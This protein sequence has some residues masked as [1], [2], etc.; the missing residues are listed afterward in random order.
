MSNTIETEIRLNGQQ[1][2]ETLKSL[3]SEV[4][5]LTSAW[6][7]EEI[8]LKS[9]GDHLQA[10]K[11][12]Y[13]GLS[14]TVNKQKEYIQKLKA[15]QSQIDQST[16][17]GA[18][19]YA[20]YGTQIENANRKLAS[21]ESQ[22]S[23]AK[24]SLNFYS[25][26]VAESKKKIDQISASSGA[27]VKRLQAEGREEEA[28]KAKLSGLKSE[29]A[30]MENLYSKQSNELSRIAKESGKASD[31]YK[32]QEI[33]VNEL[34]AKLATTK[35]DITDLS[36]ATGKVKSSPFTRLKEAIGGVSKE[37]KEGASN[38]K[39]FLGASVVSNAIVSGFQT[40]KNN[41]KGFLEEGLAMNEAGQKIADTWRNMG[42]NDEGV[43][44][45]TNQV[46]QLKVQ[47]GFAGG[48]LNSLQKS[49]DIVTNG[50]TKKTIG[51]TKSIA[52]IGVASHLTGEQ[53][54]TLGKSLIKTASSAKVSAGSLSRLEKIAPSLATALAKAAGVTQEKFA[55]MVQS[56]AI[57]GDKLKEL[58][59]KA[60]DQNEEVFQKFAKTN[61]GASARIKAVWNGLKSSLS[62][63][64]FEVK[65]SGLNQ[66]ADILQSPV[67]QNAANAIGEGIK[68][69]ANYAIKLLNYINQ[70]RNTIGAIFND[71]FSI[72]K[73]FFS[74][75]WK[76]FSD[77][78]KNIANAFS[79]LSGNAEQST[80][81]L[82][83]TKNVLDQIAQN[84]AG[85]EL[86]AKAFAAL[87]SVKG[88]SKFLSNVKDVSRALGSIVPAKPTTSVETAEV[89]TASKAGSLIGGAGIT[90][91][92]GFDLVQAIKA[93]NPDEKF[94]KYGSSIGT[95]IGGGIGLVFGKAQSAAVGGLLGQV[96]GGAG[97][98]A[99]KS[100]SEG[101]KKA[102]LGIKPEGFLQTIGFDAKKISDR[103]GQ[104]LL[105]IKDKVRTALEPISKNI[106]K[107]L[108]PIAT[109]VSK[110]IAPIVKNLQG[111]FKNVPSFFGRT[112]SSINTNLSKALKPIPNNIEKTFKGLPKTINNAF[113]IFK[114][115]AKLFI[116][117]VSK[118]FSKM[119]KDINAVLKPLQKTFT[120]V[121]KQIEKALTP[122]Q[123]AF[124]KTFKDI[125][126]AVKP[127]FKDFS[128]LIKDFLKTIGY[129]LPLAL[130]AF[131]KVWSSVWSNISKIVGTVFKI[132]EPLISS[133]MKV[134]GSVIS[135]TLRV[136]ANL[137][138][139]IWN[140]IKKI[141]V[142][143]WNSI[144][145]VVQSSL[146]IIRDVIKTVTD[147]IRGNWKAVWQDIRNF[148]KDTMSGIFNFLKNILKTIADT[149]S[150]AL[151]VIKTGWKNGWNAVGN[152]FKNVFTGLKGIAATA[153]NGVIHVINSVIGAINSV[154]HFFS[155]KNALSKLNYISTK[156]NGGKVGKERLTMINDGNGPNW[157]ELV[158]KPNGDLFMSSKRNAILM[159][160]EG[161]RVYS[162][163]ETKQIMDDNG[164]E[165]YANGGIVGN[166]GK[167][168]GGAI[169]W[170]KGTLENIGS[171]IG[172]KW[173]TLTN[174]LKDPVGNVSKMFNKAIKGMLSSLGNFG[175]LAL[176]VV[177]K[178]V[179]PVADWF[180]SQL[181]PLKKKHDDEEKANSATAGIVGGAEYWRPYVLKAL[182]MNG[183]S[184][185]LVG[186]VLSQIS[187]ESGGNPRAINL[188]D[189]NA[190]AGHPSKGLM[191]TIDSTFNAYAFPGH[192]DIWNG[193]DNILAAL[194]YAKHRYGN[195]LSFLGHGHGYANGGIANTPSIFGEAGA[196]M[197]IP[198][199]SLKSSRGYE[200][201]GRTASIF[202]SR[203]N[204][205]NQASGDDESLRDKLN[206]IITLLKQLLL[207]DPTELVSAIA[208]KFEVT[209]EVKLDKNKLAKTIAPDLQRI[210]AT[211]I[212]QQKR[213]LNV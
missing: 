134:I 100:F 6:K 92:A 164:I 43:K 108:S 187:T 13:D 200:L 23:R 64:L 3:K 199:D 196:E 177:N 205:S 139:S 123:K 142:D 129:A 160:E 1:P 116:M 44:Q 34:G 95:L 41:A 117:P 61:E 110:T 72:S 4:S 45:L 140:S 89:A 91:G 189:S 127:F 157:K 159:L 193:F 212:A 29:Y 32:K 58:L 144:K 203:D 5:S 33:R 75:V 54:E 145:G 178:L 60:A 74:T 161:T 30:E 11:S 52:E 50:D 156:A 143:V 18:E 204:L 99:A 19:S 20:K 73:L 188:W 171:W 69:I 56:G 153:L 77:L 46:K 8:Q 70:N 97:G 106:S 191:Q 148:L 114:D 26:G 16:N 152:L 40:I 93:K 213:G 51:I 179:E 115:I 37:A 9:S 210:L 47:T 22:Q 133:S 132:I 103:I 124:G 165:H 175:E 151:S 59:Y 55:A 211:K 130:G 182:K 112:F 126:A 86:T 197:A 57:T 163:S 105:P 136:T 96:I 162:G 113:S 109:N 181:T 195:N 135:N 25:S 80:D 42:K 35:K 28:N 118:A 67:I 190:Q 24:D 7:A 62:K 107:A 104:A 208:G 94:K 2:V 14:S 15:E 131:L 82:N 68:N 209:T 76:T 184:D 206:T 192:N 71:I 121:W 169:N 128:I 141:V 138:S 102:N 147:I 168:M 150:S 174:F 66:L 78:I 120:S 48:E 98:K 36:E 202:A 137:W 38:F 81:P 21:L 79:S 31:A 111:A 154:W 155:G 173:E 17:K 65:A 125:S 53:T 176:G 88:I 90:L 183:L 149:I 49:V 10:A 170:A 119:G 101:W 180:K 194:N 201:L 83:K 87:V 12:K 186:V 146:K 122:L 198:L 185:S 172:D 158:Q 27:Y 39:S 63:P 166:I 167:A 85:I 207:N 84:H